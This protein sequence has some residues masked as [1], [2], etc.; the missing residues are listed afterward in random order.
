MMTGVGVPTTT[1]RLEITD[2][3]HSLFFLHS[4]VPPSASSAFYAPVDLP[5]RYVHPAYAK[6]D[7]VTA[8]T[9]PQHLLVFV[10]Q[11]NDRLLVQ[12]GTPPPI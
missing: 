3:L 4:L 5:T 6:I 8:L 2:N 10:P 1:P 9:N 11:S 12:I 7:G